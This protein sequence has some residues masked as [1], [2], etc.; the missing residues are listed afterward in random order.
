MET[1]DV[2][3]WYKRGRKE[4]EGRAFMS[5][6]NPLRKPRTQNPAQDT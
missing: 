6:Q 4:E 5:T 1:R 3:T 2:T